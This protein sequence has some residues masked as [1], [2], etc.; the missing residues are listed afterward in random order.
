VSELPSV[1]K[2]IKKLKVER[3]KVFLVDDHQI[4]LDGVKNMIIDEADIEFCG[5]A[6]N[7]P[8][9]L[10]MIEAMNPDVVISD[11]SMPEMTGTE[12]TKIL[13]EKNIE[14][15]I[16]ILSMYTTDDCILNAIKS[17][18]KGIL[19]KQDTNKD[20]LLDAIRTIYKG[21]EYYAPSISKKIM[22]TYISNV[23]NGYVADNSK[24]FTLTNREKE[25]LKL[26]VEGNSN[27]EVAQILN[28]SIRTVETHKNNIM[29]KFHFKS[30]VEMVK[31]ALKNNL[32]KL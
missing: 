29:Q 23:K 17:G 5:F 27:Q 10:K 7:A 18:A 24:K 20:M 31:F 16:L 11:I 1:L 19:P 22:N 9:A 2:L 15:K 25:I 8:T 26:Y 6:S 13:T 12:L 3:I 32:V 14:A 21:G 30:T 4:I 28:I